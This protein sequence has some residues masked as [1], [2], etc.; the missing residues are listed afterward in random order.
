M[1]L[2]QGIAPYEGPWKDSVSASCY[3]RRDIRVWQMPGL[4]VLPQD[5]WIAVSLVM[6]RTQGL[7]YGIK[8]KRMI[9]IPQILGSR[10]EA[11]IR[12][13]L[14]TVGQVR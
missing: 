4:M 6:A 9:H 14:D 13:D 10:C 12:I 8:D 5:T 1:Y 7:G 3:K 11:R 2:I